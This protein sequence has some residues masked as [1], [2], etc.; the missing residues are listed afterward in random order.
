MEAEDLEGRLDHRLAARIGLA[1]DRTVLRPDGQKELGREPQAPGERGEGVELPAD[2]DTWVHPDHE[3]DRSR[4]HQKGH[5][6]VAQRERQQEDDQDQQ[7][8]IFSPAEVVAPAEDQPGEERDRH[9]ADRVNL[10]VDDRLVPYG[11]RRRGD[12]N[13]GRGTGAAE[14]LALREERQNP[15][16]D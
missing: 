9:Q 4:R 7:V 15:V 3:Q 2:Q 11:E 6:V 8:V 13:R 1:D 16:D 14:E 5:Q 12:Q 10:L